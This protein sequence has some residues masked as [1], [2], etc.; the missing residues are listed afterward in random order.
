MCDQ[1]LLNSLVLEARKLNLQIVLDAKGDEGVKSALIAYENALQQYPKED[2]RYLVENASITDEKLL[3]KM[4][5]LK[6]A[7]TLT[8]QH[9]FYWE[10]ACKERL[11]CEPRIEQIDA[12][13]KAKKLGLK[14]TF[15]DD[16]TSSSCHPLL[17]LE[18]ASVQETLGRS[19]SNLDERLT[20]DDAIKA[21][22]LNAAW[23]TFRE[24]E[25]GRYRSRQTG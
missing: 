16:V 17:L 7:P 4:Q 5:V 1:P 20:V 8:N 22:T 9:V 2:H 14:F 18:I 12:A 15:N 11:L 10:M 13:A 23:Q 21:M 25:L 6:V 24:K 3:E 19:R